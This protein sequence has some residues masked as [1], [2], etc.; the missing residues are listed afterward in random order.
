MKM[1]KLICPVCRAHF[2][3]KNYLVWVLSTP[4]HWFLKRKTK[5]PVC[6]SYSYMSRVKED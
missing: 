2:T 4:F 6:D 1:V 5:C 3:Y